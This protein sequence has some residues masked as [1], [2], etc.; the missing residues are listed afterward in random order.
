MLL[1]VIAYLWCACKNHD[2]TEGLWSFEFYIAVL[3]IFIVWATYDF[4]VWFQIR[5]ELLM[6]GIPIEDING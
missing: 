6:L 3:C 1:V 2:L 4:N 5:A